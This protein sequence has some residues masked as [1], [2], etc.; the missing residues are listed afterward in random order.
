MQNKTLLVTDNF[1]IKLVV[2]TMH[3]PRNLESFLNQSNKNENLIL[4]GV[5]VYERNSKGDY[6]KI[7]DASARAIKTKRIVLAYHN[8]KGIHAPRYG[9]ELLMPVKFR[10][11]GLR[12]GL[13]G[14]VPVF[15]RYLPETDIE[16][17]NYLVR[18]LSNKSFIPFYAPYQRSGQDEFQ[19]LF[20]GVVEDPTKI[21]AVL[22]N[23]TDSSV[24]S[25]SIPKE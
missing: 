21:P 22:L 9:T 6:E 20:E 19:R 23:V 13:I 24:Y 25:M 11:E 4:E 5:E 8:S 10:V 16:K 18:Q 15:G 2:D 12:N 14:K 7:S 1:E 17:L 3:S